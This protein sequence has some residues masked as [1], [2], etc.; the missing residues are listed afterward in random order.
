MEDRYLGNYQMTLEK[1]VRMRYEDDFSASSDHDLQKFERFERHNEKLEKRKAKLCLLFP[2][3][4]PDF[5]PSMIL[6]IV[7]YLAKPKDVTRFLSTMKILYQTY[8]S[9]ESSFS[10][11]IWQSIERS[12]QTLKPSLL[13]KQSPQSSKG[14]LYEKYNDMRKTISE[15]FSN[16][17]PKLLLKHTFPATHSHGEVKFIK[18]SQNQ[19]AMCA[20]KGN[21]YTLTSIGKDKVDKPKQS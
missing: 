11:H 1:K 14:Y 12:F 6:L 2:T 13:S 20:F 9:K 8:L 16:E 19:L 5:E 4:F 21:S 15:D 7:D 17:E 18:N 10:V 3:R